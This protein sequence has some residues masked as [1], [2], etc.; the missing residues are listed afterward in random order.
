LPPVSPAEFAARFGAAGYGQAH[1]ALLAKFIGEYSAAGKNRCEIMERLW[2]DGDFDSAMDRGLSASE[3]SK[4]LNYLHREMKC[5][6]RNAS[7]DASPATA[8]RDANVVLAA[9]ARA[10]PSTAESYMEAIELALE[11]ASDP[12]EVATLA[13]SILA[14]ASQNLTSAEYSQVEA[15]ASVLVSSADYW[16]SNVYTDYVILEPA[17]EANCY[18]TIG[19]RQP[20]EFLDVSGTATPAS[21]GHYRLV[22]AL[23]PINRADCSDI[24]SWKNI[25]RVD[26]S[27]FFVSL[28]VTGGNAAAALAAGTSASATAFIGL[29]VAYF[30]CVLS[31]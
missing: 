22:S 16:Y 18:D 30:I 28:V 21:G 6:A 5:A 26:G 15:G 19:N 31:Q 7:D 17:I 8:P 4:A 14:S 3:R 20:C 27:V 2:L 25:A 1:N 24:L 11:G 13:S 29:G 9:A 10:A 23:S 12:T